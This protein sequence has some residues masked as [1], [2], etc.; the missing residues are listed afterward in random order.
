MARYRARAPQQVSPAT[1]TPTGY[2]DIAGHLLGEYDGNGNLIEETVW[3]G[4]L[5]VGAL[6]PNGAMASINYVHTT[7]T[8][9][10]VKRKERIRKTAAGAIG[11][12]QKPAP[13]SA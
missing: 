10:N 12:P 5:P 2:A 1:S 13:L 6:R 3:L 11:R 8:G 9:E 7:E 4:D